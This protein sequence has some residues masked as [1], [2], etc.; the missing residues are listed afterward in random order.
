MAA[1][2]LSK[3]MIN[4]E[5][6]FYRTSS[7]RPGLRKRKSGV[8]EKKENIDEVISIPDRKRSK[9]KSKSKSLKRIHSEAEVASMEKELERLEQEQS[10]KESLID[11]EEVDFIDTDLPEYVRDDYNEERNIIQLDTLEELYP[12]VEQVHNS[13]VGHFG[14]F[15]TTTLLESQGIRMPDLLNNVMKIISECVVCQKI[16]SKVKKG[17]ISDHVL[18]GGPPPFEKTYSD[19]L[20]A[21]PIS[22]KGNDTIF[23]CMDSFSRTVTLRAI[24]G[25]TTEAVIPP[26]LEH[27]CRYGPSQIHMTDNASNFTSKLFDD[28]RK[29]CKVL[30]LTSLPH[31]H[32]ANG[33]VERANKEILRHLSA[34]VYD[35]AENDYSKWD[36]YLPLVEHIMN[37][38]VHSATG[39]EPYFLLYGSAGYSRS[40]FDIKV[41]NTGLDVKDLSSYVRNFDTAMKVIRN[42]SVYY[43]DGRHIKKLENTPYKYPVF[44]KGD[45]AI[46]DDQVRLQRK[47]KKLSTRGRGPVQVMSYV[48]SNIY[49]CKDLTQDKLYR[50]HAQ[51]L[52]KF[53]V[54]CL[55]GKTREES[56]RHLAKRD[57]R[58]DLI[59]SVDGHEGGKKRSARDVYFKCKFEGDD[60]HI[61]MPFSQVR[62]VQLVKDYVLRTPELEF[63]VSRLIVDDTHRLKK[64]SLKQRQY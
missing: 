61:F 33:Q 41:E 51:D 40:L 6:H 21:L 52:T 19:L 37:T 28:F 8:E 27:W 55:E 7:L 4:T 43:Q 22:E 45:Y 10:L 2:A 57:D 15:K 54:K 59:V 1:D 34:I 50:F 53:Y 38:S 16:R 26:L 56:A 18:Q 62:M 35:L 63:L 60:E 29:R 11:L 49:E 64:S 14:A 24:Q 25:V 39:Y 5:D 46:V 42:S 58:E 3:I 30:H 31:L 36:I 48:G 20:Q 9:S 17:F 13:E 32:T 23:V 12:Y 47:G 44:G